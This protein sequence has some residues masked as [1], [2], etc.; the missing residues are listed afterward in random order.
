MK[1]SLIAF[2]LFL[3]V[4]PS[5]SK[6][7]DVTDCLSTYGS[8]YY[9]LIN[10]I[11]VDGDLLG[12]GN[13]CIDIANNN[14]VFDLND[15]GIYNR[16]QTFLSGVLVRSNLKNVTI[17]NGYIRDFLNI[18]TNDISA[19]TVSCGLYGCE[20]IV[21]SN[22]KISNCS[23]GGYF[24]N[25]TNLRIS[26]S[27]FDNPNG[28]IGIWANYIY[29]SSI[30]AFSRANTYALIL[31]NSN[32]TFI[33]GHY[34]TNVITSVERNVTGFDFWNF[35]SWGLIPPKVFGT[36]T[37]QKQA[38][39]IGIYSYNN[40]NNVYQDVSAIGLIQGIYA[41]NSNLNTFARID[42]P[43]SNKKTGGKFGGIYLDP[44]SIE[45]N[46]CEITGLILDDCNQLILTSTCASKKNYYFD[47]CANIFVNTTFGVKQEMGNIFLTPLIPIVI[48]NYPFVSFLTT[49]FFLSMFIS[50]MV[51]IYVTM[52]TNAKFGL[53]SLLIIVSLL[54]MVQLAT[55]W[56]SFIFIVIMFFVSV[57]LFKQ[58][59][60][61]EVKA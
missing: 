8:G 50:T 57:Y 18:A 11:F 61:K 14:V 39:G 34:D 48:P 53:Y 55:F 49:P 4:F 3:L 2:L 38:E 13:S 60:V 27:A 45:N 47:T 16:N 44:T 30:N 9:R 54:A 40:S 26:A 33:S 56:F 21:I 35:I 58:Q 43:L 19:I 24:R 5:Y 23:I 28:K 37:V 59:E 41:K 42:L 52:K 46:L 32:S 7:T 31:G 36:E 20:N 51:S 10:D 6:A 22:V 29:N 12:T 25:I 1:K 17:M 15:Y